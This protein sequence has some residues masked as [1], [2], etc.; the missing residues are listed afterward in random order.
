MWTDSRSLR[1]STCSTG[2]YG[3]GR[4]LEFKV[5]T[6]E[7]GMAA[8][9]R[10]FPFRVWFLLFCFA[11]RADRGRPR[12]LCRSN[13]RLGRREGKHTRSHLWAWD[14]RAQLLPEGAQ[15]CKAEYHTSCSAIN[16]TEAEVGISSLGCQ[17]G[18]LQEG[19]PVANWVE[20]ARCKVYRGTADIEAPKQDGAGGSAGIT[21]QLVLFGKGEYEKVTRRESWKD[22]QT[23]VRSWWG[24]GWA[25]PGQLFEGNTQMGVWTEVTG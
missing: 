17:G 7:P 8:R 21:S 19:P 1:V 18:F 6:I 16:T 9:L 25:W 22:G 15:R 4:G 24:D 3:V 5:L 13:W 11:G 20:L 14:G 10:N 12:A 23:D 2:A